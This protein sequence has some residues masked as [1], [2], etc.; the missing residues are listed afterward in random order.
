MQNIGDELDFVQIVRRNAEDHPGRIAVRVAGRRGLTWADVDRRARAVAGLL[1]KEHAAGDRVAL[2]FDTD[3]DFLPALF[4][5]WYAGL[6]AVPLP[7]GRAGE[8]LVQETGP[9]AVLT[10]GAVRDAVASGLDL[11]PER[12][13]HPTAVLQYTSGSTG[14][15]KGVLVTHDNYMHNMRMIDEFV[16]SFQPW[17]DEPQ[18]VSWLPHFHDMGLTLLLIATWRAGTA[19]MISPFGFV[20]DPAVWLRTISE[21]GGHITAAPNFAYDLCTRRVPAEQVAGLDLST[22]AVMLNAAEPVRADTVDRF[23]AHFAAAGLRRRAIAPCFGLAEGTVFVSGVRH[24]EAPRVLRFDRYA[25]QTGFGAEEPITGRPLVSCGYRPE[26]LTVRIVD[27]E[28]RLE[29]RAGKIG[30][31]WV[32]GPSVAAG[33]A[34]GTG[35]SGVFAGRIAGFDERAYLRTGDLGF[36]WGGELFVAGRLADVIR[37]DDR[38]LFPEDLEH[39]VER[40]TPRL[41]GRRCAVVALDDTGTVRLAALAEI[42]QTRPLEPAERAAI[43]SAIRDAVQAEHAVDIDE[44]RLLPTGAIPVT[45]SGKVQRNRA[46]AAILGWNGVAPVPGE[47]P[48]AT[49]GSRGYRGKLNIS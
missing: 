22:M 19:T 6:V 48:K 43:E 14:A 47:D 29:C 5:C 36:V 12:A 8:N 17:I 42:R 46:R 49:P 41:Y 35:D 37:F 38:I 3:E 20:R 7:P 18:V 24:T 30:E 26:G 33:Y 11:V 39:T 21:V 32:H 10:A 34:P 25:L 27:P 16:R 13:T 44:I 4:G 1:A 23:V 45:T 9:A 40:S 31:I 15:R 28:S 2:I